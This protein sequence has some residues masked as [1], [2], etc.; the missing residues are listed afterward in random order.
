MK[1]IG[2]KIDIDR[3]L[4]IDGLSGEGTASAFHKF[5]RKG[6]GKASEAY[7]KFYVPITS[8][9]IDPLLDAAGVGPGVRVLDVATG[10][11]PVASRCFDREAMVIGVDISEKMVALAKRLHPEIKFKRTPA[12]N[13]PFADATFD[14]VVANFFVPHMAE[15]EPTVCELVRVLK[16][17]GRLALTTWD[18]AENNRL[19]GIFYDAI[20]QAG[21]KPP[22]KLPQGSPM[23]ELSEEGKFTKILTGAGLNDVHIETIKFSQHFKNAE[24]FWGGTL[25]S[26]V[27]TPALILNQ[28]EDIQKRIRAL[29][30]GMIKR[31]QMKDGSLDIPVSIKL[32]SG[33][34]M[35]RQRR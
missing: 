33:M 32:G 13:L 25:A 1:G 24:E 21:A 11:G 28:P 22:P 19:L 4:P 15:P 18:I 6:W 20:S 26:G 9:V 14:A 12:E 23:F 2:I 29:Y 8:R 31:Y 35:I 3:I 27:R 16:P 7:N 30:H 17:G 10:P 34:K 5:E